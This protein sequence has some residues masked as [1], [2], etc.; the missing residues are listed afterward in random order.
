MA[1]SSIN[2]GVERISRV[3]RV[4]PAVRSQLRYYCCIADMFDKKE[5]ILV[6]LVFETLKMA[7][8]TLSVLAL[9]ISIFLSKLKSMF[10]DSG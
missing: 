9:L 3:D 10:H 2:E 4:L 7:M 5:W 8:V 6:V 1:S